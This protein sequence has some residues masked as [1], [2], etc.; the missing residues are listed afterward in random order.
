M[1]FCEFSGLPLCKST[2][3]VFPFSCCSNRRIRTILS[4]QRKRNTGRTISPE[5]S[6]LR[7]NGRES[8]PGLDHS[9]ESNSEVVSPHN[10]AP[11]CLMNAC[12]ASN[13]SVSFAPPRF[14]ASTSARSECNMNSR[15][16]KTSL[17]PPPPDHRHSA[18]FTSVLRTQSAHSF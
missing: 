10:A 14:S 6:E 11:H 13:Q 4:T 12:S 8:S 7:S 3:S 9:E 5:R 1:V 15:L 2:K 18:A 17:I 16:L